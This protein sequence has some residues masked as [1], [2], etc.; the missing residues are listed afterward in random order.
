MRN[1][2]PA[3]FRDKRWFGSIMKIRNKYWKVAPRVPL[4]QMLRFTLVILRHVHMLNHHELLSTPQ[5]FDLCSSRQ[6]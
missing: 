4:L 6:L 3:E 2:V 5:L 1:V